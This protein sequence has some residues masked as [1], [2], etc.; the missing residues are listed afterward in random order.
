VSDC[1]FC[2]EFVGETRN[3]FAKRYGDDLSDRVLIGT[4]RFR[5]VPSLGQIV[6]GHLLIVPMMHCR[7]LADM[8]SEDINRLKDFCE[9][10]RSTLRDVYGECVFFEH[11]IRSEGSGGCGID[12]AHMHAV[13]VTADG[14]LAALTHEFGG[15]S[16]QSLSDIKNTL[17]TNSSYLFFEN[18]SAQRYVFPVK[19][20][21]SQYMRRLVAESIGKS[22]W[23]WRACGHEPELISTVKR[24]SPLFS[25]PAPSHR[26]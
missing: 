7:A 13:P 26:G 4:D 9:Q 19:N 6:E 18:A 10:V 12:H 23:D 3:A 21:P 16:I 11:G 8:P 25:P 15:S 1:D 24:L 14:V 17:G 20:L 5:V 2:D 22:D